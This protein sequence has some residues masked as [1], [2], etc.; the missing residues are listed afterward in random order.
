MG[1]FEPESRPS[2]PA[3]GE[4]APHMS[5]PADKPLSEGHGRLLA[6]AIIAGLIAGAAASLAN[7][8]VLKRY[9][10]D[11]TPLLTNA[12]DSEAIRKFK[13]ARLHSSVLTFTTL[14]GFFGLTMGL[15]GGLAR[16]SVFAGVRAAVPVGL[17]GAAAAAALAWLLVSVFFQRYDPQSGDLVLPLLTHGALWSTVGAL[18]GLA[19][20]L[21][22]GQGRWKATVVGGLVGAAAATVV[23]EIVGALAFSSS[24]ADMPVSATVT[25]RA[26]AQL[27]VAILSAVGAVLALSASA[28]NAASSRPS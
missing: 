2:N 16:R 3:A 9:H 17:L 8:A 1:Q 15:A 20:G 25:T 12:P 10:N 14:G 24:K 21:G 7:E 28:Q 26:M 18:G 22:L 5:A 11:L 13:E 19:F 23:Y 27:L 4:I 6:L